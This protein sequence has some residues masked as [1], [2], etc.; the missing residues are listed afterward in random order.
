MSTEP[1]GASPSRAGAWRLQW[2]RVPL[3]CPK[4]LVTLIKKEGCIWVTEAFVCKDLLDMVLIDVNCT[5]NSH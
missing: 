3:C 2:N 4:L 1:S 5:M